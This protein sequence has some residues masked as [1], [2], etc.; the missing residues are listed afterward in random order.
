MPTDPEAVHARIA[1]HPRWYHRIQVAPGVTTPGVHDSP[2]ALAQLDALGLP[3]NCRGLRVLD[4]GCRDGFFAFEMERRGGTVL[5][6]D[7]L[8]P[9]ETGFSIAAELLGSNVEYSVDNVYNLTRKRYGT[10]DLVLFLGVLYHLR[11]PMLALDRVR[12][13]VEPGALVW[14]ETQM[15]PNPA[16]AALPEPVWQIFPRDTLHADATNEWAPNPA[17]PDTLQHRQV[18]IP[19]IGQPTRRGPWR[20]GDEIVEALIE[21]PVGAYEAVG[22]HTDRRVAAPVEPFGE[23]VRGVRKRLSADRLVPHGMQAREEGGRGGL[24]P[25]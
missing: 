21:T 20:Q 16:L 24:G 19:S 25:R 10:F 4:V 1:A 8:G 3:T 14:V 22:T 13:V 17:G 18:H 5:A 23:G 7:Y 15:I 12:E 6:L 11:N 9:T 2:A